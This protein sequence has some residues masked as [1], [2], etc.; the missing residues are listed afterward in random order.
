MDLAHLASRKH[1]LAC[2]L[3]ME[4]RGFERF[5]KFGLRGTTPEE[6]DVKGM[7]GGIKLSSC[8]SR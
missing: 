6:T 2:H 1:L 8:P 4:G 7:S 5:D 3:L